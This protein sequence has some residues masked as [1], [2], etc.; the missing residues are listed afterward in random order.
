MNIDTGGKA[1]NALSVYERYKLYISDD[2]VEH[3]LDKCR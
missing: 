3:E 2:H 1:T